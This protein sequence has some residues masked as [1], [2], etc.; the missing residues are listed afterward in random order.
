[1]YFLIMYFIIFIGFVFAMYISMGRDVEDFAN[2]QN[3]MY[4]S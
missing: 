2:V 1:M 4:V 3:S